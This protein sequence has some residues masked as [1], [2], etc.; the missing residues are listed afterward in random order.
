MNIIKR[1]K[2]KT[3]KYMEIINMVEINYKVNK[4]SKNTERGCLIG[5]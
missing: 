3:L 1:I 4:M 2:N 5:N